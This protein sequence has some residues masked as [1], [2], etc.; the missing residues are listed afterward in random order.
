MLEHHG[1]S[2]GDLG[3]L[4][5]HQANARIIDA[6]A[7]ALGLAPGRVFA[8]VERYGNTSNASIP[9]ALVE[10]ERAGR[11]R[12]GQPVLLVAFGAGLTWGCSLLR[13]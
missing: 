2:I 13:W 12:P 8:N 3:L 1:L 11:L 4:V 7:R 5:P 6:A 10:A 9:L